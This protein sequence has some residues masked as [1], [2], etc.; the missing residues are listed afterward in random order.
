MN[1]ADEPNCFSE[2]HG[3]AVFKKDCFP[4]VNTAK[5]NTYGVK[6]IH[7]AKANG[8]MIIMDECGNLECDAFSFQHEILK[9]L[10]EAVP[11]LGVIKQ[12]STGWTDSI[13]NH[14]QV[15]LIT[16]TKDNR[17]AL[18]QILVDYYLMNS[19]LEIP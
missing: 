16:V 19:H 14:Y 7:S 15:K 12:D 8:A 5:F 10:D 3:I 4:Q 18:P 9:T 6:L 1:R 13:R 17:N 11:V 2:N